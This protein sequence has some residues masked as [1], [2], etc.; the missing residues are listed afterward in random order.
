MVAFFCDIGAFGYVTFCDFE[1]QQGDVYVVTTKVLF[2][3]GEMNFK[4]LRALSITWHM[5]TFARPHHFVGGL[6]RA[7]H[8]TWIPVVLT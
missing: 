6:G 1:R 8:L 7:V 2:L 4:L 3:P 5:D